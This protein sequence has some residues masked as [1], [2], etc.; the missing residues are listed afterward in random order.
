MRPRSFGWNSWRE[1][2]GEKRGKGERERREGGKREWERREGEERGREKRVGEERGRGERE[3]KESGRGEKER[4]E[5]EEREK[6]AKWLVLIPSI[7]P[8]TLF[9]SYSFGPGASTRAHTTAL[10]LPTFEISLDLFWTVSLWV[11]CDEQWL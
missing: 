6:V 2:V 7:P 9:F 5:R 8:S 3:G 10:C 11:N 4:R 1:R